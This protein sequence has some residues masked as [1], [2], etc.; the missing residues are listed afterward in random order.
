MIAAVLN[1]TW[2]NAVE[3][4]PKHLKIFANADEDCRQCMINTGT[5]NST[6][7]IILIKRKTFN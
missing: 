4:L 5:Y 3:N 6:T 7:N 2:T 1:K